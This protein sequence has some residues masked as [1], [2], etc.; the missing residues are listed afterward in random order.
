MH[1][2]AGPPVDPAFPALSGLAFAPD[3]LRVVT[4][5]Y[6][7]RIHILDS[8]K[9]ELVRTFDAVSLNAPAAA[10]AQR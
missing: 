5:G 4:G 3:S 2:L 7:G 8:A 9:C 6:D 10:T 1:Q